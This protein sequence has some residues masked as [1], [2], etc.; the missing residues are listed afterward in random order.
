MRIFTGDNSETKVIPTWQIVQGDTET[1]TRFLIDVGQLVPGTF[2]LSSNA[3]GFCSDAGEAAFGGNIH[4]GQTWKHSVPF[5]E[6]IG[7]PNVER[8]SIT[9]FGSPE[10]EQ[11]GTT[12]IEALQPHQADVD[13]ALH[14]T[15][16][17]LLEASSPHGV[18]GRDLHDP[19]QLRAAHMTLSDFE[20]GKP[21]TTM[22]AAIGGNSVVHG[23]SSQPA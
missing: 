3:S 8:A 2:Q 4:Y 20:R 12:H 5:Q 11:T 14:M 7:V 21:T 17:R 10:R 6:T 22:E 16:E 19:L 23:R 1:A 9:L 18:R 13:E 15:N